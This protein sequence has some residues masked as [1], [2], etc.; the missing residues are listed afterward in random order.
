MNA[1]IHQQ[2]PINSP[3]TINCQIHRSVAVLRTPRVQQLE[4]IFDVPPSQKSECRWTHHFTLPEHW[5]IGIIVGPSGSGKSTLA[6][7]AFGEHLIDQW[8]WPPDK[9]IV[10][11]FPAAM[12]IRDITAL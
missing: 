12:S 8:N 10:D 2:P 3:M 4:G 1:R 11:G 9:S 7:E 5:N 6:R